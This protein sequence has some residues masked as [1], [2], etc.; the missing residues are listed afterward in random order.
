MYQLCHLAS[1]HHYSDYSQMKYGP[2][3]AYIFVRI[4]I[5][6][7]QL[8]SKTGASCIYV[9]MSIH[10]PRHVE[11]LKILQASCITQRAWWLSSTVPSVQPEQPCQTHAEPIMT[12][13]DHSTDLKEDLRAALTSSLDT[14]IRIPPRRY[15]PQPPLRTSETHP[16]K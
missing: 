1:L 15:D 13:T 11:H 14:R 6:A 10:V 2:R 16:I 7:A 12:R 9:P 8:L 3:G 4:W 5:T